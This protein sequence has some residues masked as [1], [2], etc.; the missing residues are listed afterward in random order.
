[1]FFEKKLFGKIPVALQAILG[2]ILF[3]FGAYMAIFSTAWADG[4]MKMFLLFV[5]VGILYMVAGMPQM[6]EG[7]MTMLYKKKE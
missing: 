6:L 7:A 2:L 3:V 4:D 5:S 1:M